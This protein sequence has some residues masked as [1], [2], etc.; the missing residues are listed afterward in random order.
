M[1]AGLILVTFLF[2]VLHGMSPV[3]TG[4]ALPLASTAPFL[5]PVRGSGKFQPL[6][7]KKEIKPLPVIS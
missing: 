7:L 1:S 6:I 5:L 2:L 3:L 4:T